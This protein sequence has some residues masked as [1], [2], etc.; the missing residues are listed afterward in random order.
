MENLQRKF[1]FIEITF[2]FSGIVFYSP[3]AMLIRTSRG[4]TVSEFLILQAILSFS[5]FFF[6]L[7]LGFLTDK[8]GYK[9]S[10]ILSSF[11]ILLARFFLLFAN[12]FQFFIVEAI[13]EGI[14]FA[15]SS[16]TISSYVYVVFGEEFYAKKSSVLYNFSNIGFLISTVGFFFINKYININYLIIFTILASIISLIFCFFIPKENSI[17]EDTIDKDYIIKLLNKTTFQFIILNSLL[18]LSMILINFF[19]VVVIQKVG[20]KSEDIMFLILA[21]T[22]FELLCPKIIDIFGEKNL[23]K[24]IFL[25][26]VICAMLFFIIP[27][28][29]SIIVFVPMI[30]LP[31][32]ISVLS[33]YI[34]KM[35][36]L[37]VDGISI[38]RRA[39]I[40]SL[41]SMGANGMDVCFLFASS[42]FV[43]NN[44][45]NLFVFI[46]TCF[47]FVAGLFYFK[48]IIYR[49]SSKI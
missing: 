42:K 27:Y 15:F 32:V 24:N 35:E 37:Y 13:L 28:I 14:H 40:L 49:D 5:I 21:Y 39:T 23:R 22:L 20:F 12:S 3:V 6:E 46:S 17:E 7:P 48:N 33:F 10:M 38:E 31:V 8:I 41:F 44:F 30:A 47:F 1:K 9:H 26:S 16:G 11:F 36:N 25:F 43:D 18:S 34:D 19:Y 4:I 2:F 29:D 45:S